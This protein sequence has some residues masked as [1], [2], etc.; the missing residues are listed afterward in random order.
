MS[1]VWCPF[2]CIGGES[3]ARFGVEQVPTFARWFVATG[4]KSEF[5]ET[6]PEKS[7]HVVKKEISDSGKS[8][9]KKPGFRLPKQGA[10]RAVIIGSPNCGKSQLLATLTNAS[11][12]IADY[13]FTTTQP[14]PGMMLWEDVPIQLVDMPPITQD[15]YDPVNQNL[16]RGADV[17]ILMLDL[18]SDDGVQLFNDVLQKIGETKTRLGKETCL[19]E[20]D[21]GVAYTATLLA[22]NKCDLPEAADRLEFFREFMDVDFEEFQISATN[23]ESL[24]ALRTRIYEQLDVVRVYTK[25]PH[26]KEADFDKPFTIRRGGTLAD[27]AEL[28]H[29]DFAKNLKSARVWGSEVHDGTPVKGDYIL[30]DKDIVEINI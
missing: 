13:P 14:L 12:V 6:P 21:I 11:P 4:L 19:D 22:I 27:V 29:K 18:G 24:E 26:K 2:L 30:H 1:G 28:I 17:V 15:V 9:G 8:G 3:C 16:I 5:G 25:M 7:S 20:D 23:E 10:G